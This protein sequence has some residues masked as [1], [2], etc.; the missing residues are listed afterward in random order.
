MF[1][2]YLN[3]TKTPEQSIQPI[4][5]G[6]IYKIWGIKDG[7]KSESHIFLSGTT[8]EA[9]EKERAAVYERYKRREHILHFELVY[10]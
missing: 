3:V 6:A 1:Y 2:Q 7:I 10:I 9:I 5:R 4:I 8:E